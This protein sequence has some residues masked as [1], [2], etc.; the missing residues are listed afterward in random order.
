MN[1]CLSFMVNEVIDY[2]AAAIVMTLIFVGSAYYLT[3]FTTSG[4]A[5]ISQINDQ[6][7]MLNL[8]DY[9]LLSTGNPP[10]WGSP[11]ISTNQIDAFGLAQTSD[12]Y[13]L[14]SL[15][16]TRL[17]QPENITIGATKLCYIPVGANYSE[18]VPCN[19]YYLNYTY[20]KQLLWVKGYEFRL[21]VQP[22]LKVIIAQI[23][24]STCSF[25]VKVTSTSGIAVMGASINGTLIYTNEEGGNNN[26]AIK[27][28]SLGIQNNQ[29]GPTNTTGEAVLT[30]TSIESGSGNPCGKGF[31][32]Y[33]TAEVGGVIDPGFYS[34]AQLDEAKIF[35]GTTGSQ[36]S[37][38]VI[39]VC[40]KDSSGTSGS[41]NPC[42]VEYVNLTQF[43]LASQ[44]FSVQ[45]LCG[46]KVNTGNG[47]GNPFSNITCP[48]NF[49]DGF[50]AVG[51]KPVGNSRPPEVVLVPI[52]IAPLGLSV[53]YGLNP[54][55]AGYAVTLVRT[56]DVDGFTYIARFTYWPDVGPVFGS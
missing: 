31:A 45:P 5:T 10:N 27:K 47:A 7:Q 32:V 53:S 14:S 8:F 22:A 6:T 11:T 51:V 55:G 30:F 16:L 50:L 9:L 46:G 35:T 25:L 56:L 54:V 49:K 28:F 15:K 23:Q 38:T 33:A 43:V 4:L 36:N 41:N 17:I 21:T 2:M 3:V 48:F 13:N 19:G 44:G 42:S 52:S 37:V 26:G 29:A 12:E 1:V 24:T 39:D 18:L 40:N 34:S 20:A